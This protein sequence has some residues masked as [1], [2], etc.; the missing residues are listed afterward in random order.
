MPGHSHPQQLVDR[1]D[2]AL[3]GQVGLLLGGVVGQDAADAERVLGTKRVEDRIDAE[4]DPAEGEDDGGVGDV[5]TVC[6]ARQGR[7]P[8]V[9]DGCRDSFGVSVAIRTRVRDSLVS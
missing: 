1:Q 6:H 5:G 3:L 4:L 9:Q 8:A 2:Q 7:E